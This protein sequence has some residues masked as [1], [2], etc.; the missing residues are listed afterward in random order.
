MPEL[1]KLRDNVKALSATNARAMHNIRVLEEKIKAISRLAARVDLSD[2]F[3]NKEQSNV[4]L[5]LAT[6]I[7]SPAADRGDIESRKRKRT[8]RILS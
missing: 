3:D 5:V 7:L 4:R 2:W 1:V 8:V 6:Q